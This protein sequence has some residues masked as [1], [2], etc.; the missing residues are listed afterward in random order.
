MQIVD[1]RILS[2]SAA[3]FADSLGGGMA[4]FTL[5]ILIGILG[6]GS[7][8]VDTL[9]GIVISTW[10]FLA[11]VFQPL[12]GKVIDSRG[13]PKRFLF[14]SL[15]LT[16]VLVLLYAK[17]RSVEELIVLRAILGIVESFLMVSSLTLLMHFAGEKKGE[18]FGIYNTFTDLGF[19]AS[20]ILA[21]LLIA[22]GVDV[23]FY[24]SS[25]LVLISALAVILL[26]EDVSDVS[27]REKSGG[28]LDLSRDT[29]PV[30]ISLSSAVALMSSI[31]PLE[32][33][34]MGRL[35]ITPFEFGLSFTIYLITRT[36]FN[37]FAGK[38]T[39]RSGAKKV[40]FLSS[41]TLSITALLLLTKSFPV[42]L[43]IRFVQGFVVALVYTSSAVFVAERSGLSYAISMSILS[44]V[45]TAGLTLGPLTA[46]FMSGYLGFEVAYMLFSAMIALPVFYE[47]VRER[48]KN[49]RATS[50]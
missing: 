22:K 19:S 8:P 35:D 10:G 4:Y 43:G 38:I 5:P 26:V 50:P 39:D 24:I 45:I 12:A 23:V 6:H 28:V 25:A 41:L 40:Y 11:T 33:S 18:S 17:V 7:L 21:G 2:I 29:I 27:V 34:F 13:H 44:S 3:R 30:L 47:V 42:F 31:V 15:I 49:G 1:R 36:L 48:I 20:P 14:S 16:S 46:G 32:N 9:S 37:T